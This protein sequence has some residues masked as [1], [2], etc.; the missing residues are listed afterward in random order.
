[1]SQESLD[2]WDNFTGSNFLKVEDVKDQNH[3]FVCIKVELDEENNRPMLVLESDDTKYK[4]S[5]NVTNSNFVK[6]AGIKKPNDL[7]GKKIKFRVTQAF[8]PSAKKE[9]DTLRVISVE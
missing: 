7:V 4:M 1:M 5:L 2:S 9:V 3:A 8:S 6:N